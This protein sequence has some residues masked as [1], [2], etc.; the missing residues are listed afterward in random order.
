MQC[1]LPDPPRAAGRC[2]SLSSSLLLVLRGGAKPLPSAATATA[3]FVVVSPGQ[4]MKV[5]GDDG[6][7]M[8]NLPRGVCIQGRPNDVHVS[9]NYERVVALQVGGVSAESTGKR[10]KGEPVLRSNRQHHTTCE[11]GSEPSTTGVRASED[12]D[13]TA[14]LLKLDKRRAI[15]KD[16]P[17]CMQSIHVIQQMET[18]VPGL[19]V[20]TARK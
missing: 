1:S 3:T 4:K 19:C 18:A 13:S 17:I 6:L 2:L 10:L 7:G 20:L 5:A 11:A 14:T 8:V 12:H 15:G 9:E 16:R